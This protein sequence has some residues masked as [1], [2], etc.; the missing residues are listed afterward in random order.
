M[1]GAKEERAADSPLGVEHSLKTLSQTRVGRPPTEP[2]KGPRPLEIICVA[3][4]A[5][6]EFLPYR[7]NMFYIFWVLVFNMHCLQVLIAKISGLCLV[8]G[9]VCGGLYYRVILKEFKLRFLLKFVVSV[10]YQKNFFLK[11]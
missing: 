5:V 9:F 6:L 4:C 7:L 8:I 10:S 3:I 2:P 1:G 11:S